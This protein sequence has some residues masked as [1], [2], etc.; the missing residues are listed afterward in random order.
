MLVADQ[1]SSFVTR[2]MLGALGSGSGLVEVESTT[3][4]EGRKKI[5]KGK[6]TALL[7]LP[8]GFGDAA[9]RETTLTQASLET[10]FIKLTGR[11]LRE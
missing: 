11:E 2:L 4:E 6:G 1:D 8:A 9:F 3:L 10:L 5:E 7:V